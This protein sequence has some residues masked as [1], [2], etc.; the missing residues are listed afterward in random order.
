MQSA[1]KKWNDVLENVQKDDLSKNI[2]FYDE[3]DDDKQSESFLSVIEN[4]EKL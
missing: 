2:T 3:D 1:L 4:F